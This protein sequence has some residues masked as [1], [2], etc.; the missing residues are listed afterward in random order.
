MINSGAL[1]NVAL[2]KPPTASPVRD[3]NCSVARTI[4]A[5]IGMMAIPA[6]K[7]T[8]GAGTRP[9]FSM[10]TVMGTKINSQ[11]MGFRRNPLIG[12]TRRNTIS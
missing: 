7:N 11:L 9:T 2:S 3:A 1:P 4:R 8:A 12:G 5:A 6:E 10:P